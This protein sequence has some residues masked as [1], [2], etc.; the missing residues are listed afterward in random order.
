MKS[1][2]TLRKYNK[3]NE[4]APAQIFFAPLDNPILE[5]YIIVHKCVENTFSRTE[6][7]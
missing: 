1:H 7:K 3:P 6:T 4:K 2:Q 5:I